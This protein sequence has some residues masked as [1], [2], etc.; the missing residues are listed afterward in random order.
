[1]Q[2]LPDTV[3]AYRRTP[4]FDAESVPAGLRSNH[5]TAAGV[6]GMITVLEGEL[7]YDIEGETPETVLLNPE[8]PGIVAPQVPHRVTPQGPVRFYVEFHR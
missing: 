6:W 8:R 4:V 5:R 1:M 7:R 2:A 3:T